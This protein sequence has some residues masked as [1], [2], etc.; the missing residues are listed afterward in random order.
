MA[1]K[2]LIPSQKFTLWQCVAT[3]I[4]LARRAIEETRE[5]SRLPGPPGPEGPEGRRG[6]Q[7]PPGPEGKGIQGEQGTPGRDGLPGRDGFSFDDYEAIDDEKEYGFRLKQNGAVLGERRWPKPV[8]NIADFYKGIWREGE[9]Q[10]GQMVTHGGSLFLAQRDTSDKPEASDAWK[11]I[12]KRGRDGKDGRN[13]EKGDRGPEG[14]AG[15]DL[16]H[17]TLDGV[18]Y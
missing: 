13:G 1:D 5:L 2:P 17:M 15:R 7:G 16:T 4:A 11:L 12:V 14:R 10:R 3:A 9:F 18:K 6:L 8:A